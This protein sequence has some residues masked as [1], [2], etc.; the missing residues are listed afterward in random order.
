[1]MMM[2]V[3]GRKKEKDDDDDDEGWRRW[4]DDYEGGR[5]K[6]G[7]RVTLKVENWTRQVS[8]QH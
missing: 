1:M 5:K 3:E 8:Y 7:R 6:E 4:L 2:E